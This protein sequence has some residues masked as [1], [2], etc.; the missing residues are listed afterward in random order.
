[1]AAIPAL[2]T[3]FFITSGVNSGGAV[4]YGSGFSVIGGG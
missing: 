3:A 4:G 1:M 2:L